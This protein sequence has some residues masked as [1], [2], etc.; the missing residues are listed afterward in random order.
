MPQYN[1]TQ[2]CIQRKRKVKGNPIANPITI[3]QILIPNE[4]KQTLRVD[5]FLL[6]DKGANDPDRNCHCFVIFTGGVITR[7]GKYLKNGKL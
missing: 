2:R 4:L 6:H 5:N 7:G 3:Q 1:T